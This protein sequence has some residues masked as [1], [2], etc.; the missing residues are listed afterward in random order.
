M[1]VVG[2]LADG[3]IGTVTLEG[4]IGNLMNLAC[5]GAY[6]KKI[7]RPSK[8]DWCFSKANSKIERR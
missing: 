2:E 1:K 4:T 8:M 5:I 6:L 7:R 3:S